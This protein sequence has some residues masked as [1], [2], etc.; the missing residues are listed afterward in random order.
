MRGQ[1]IFLGFKE[2]KISTLEL[3]RN[4]CVFVSH[5][6]EDKPFA[7]TVAN[8]LIE[9]GI[10]VYFDEKDIVLQQALSQGDDKA[11]VACIEAGLEKCSHLLGIITENTKKSWWVPYEIGGA[12]G[13]KRECA[14]LISKE[15][16][17]LPSYIKISKLLLD[18]DDF[19]GWLTSPSGQTKEMLKESISFDTMSKLTEQYIPRFRSLLNV[20]FYQLILES[21]QAKNLATQQFLALIY[22]IFTTQY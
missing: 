14:H 4:F 2:G 8:T 21:V 6:K 9:M 3:R 20:T 16:K 17:Q 12:T 1:N 22:K 5:Q 18:I 11:I 13:R 19:T 10:D 15:V 7:R